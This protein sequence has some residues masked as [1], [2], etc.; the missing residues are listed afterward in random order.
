MDFIN[1]QY[2]YTS[3]FDWQRGGDALSEV[4]SDALGYETSI[5]TVQNANTHNL[6]ATL[7]MQKFYDLI[8]LKKRDGKGN[9]RQAPIRRDKAGNAASETK[10]P[11]QKTSALFNTAIDIVTMVKR[12]NV[13]YNESNGTVLP[14]Y[15]QSVGFVGT[16]RPTIGFV[17]GNQADVRY[18]AARNGWLT[19]FADFNEQF[20][21]ED[22]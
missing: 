4:A 12:L 15:T 1:A 8:G 18:E 11:E 19:N 13:N 16:A 6:T 17:F 3:N 22:Q 7:S 9:T 20:I 21:K 14:G 2:S 10:S 5:N